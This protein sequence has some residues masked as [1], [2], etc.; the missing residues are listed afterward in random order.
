[1]SKTLRN[2]DYSDKDSGILERI[3]QSR[4]ALD[5]RRAHLSEWVK[6]TDKKHE[7]AEIEYIDGML[8]WL[9]FGGPTPFWISSE[10]SR[11]PEERMLQ[12]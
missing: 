7:L 1:M 12:I 3:K 5:M 11:K 10:E 2:I 4:K 6:Y 9:Q 8:A